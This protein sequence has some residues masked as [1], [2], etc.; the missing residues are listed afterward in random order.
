MIFQGEATEAIPDRR[1][2][3]QIISSDSNNEGTEYDNPGEWLNLSLGRN[4]LSTPGDSDTQQRPASTKVFPCNFCMRKF[5]SSQA[6]GGHQ[7]AHKRERGAAKRYQSHRMMAMMGLPINTPMARSLGVRPHTLVHKPSRELSAIVARFT[8][9]KTGFGMARMPFT[10]EDPTDLMWPGSF[11]MN[12]KPSE[13]P[14]E[15]HKL[16]LN[17]RL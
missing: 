12:P 13:P 6:L 9:A 1:Q 7:N 4:L 16:D 14:S 5:F 8:D 10:M 3:D 17:L 11:R 15:P 2:G